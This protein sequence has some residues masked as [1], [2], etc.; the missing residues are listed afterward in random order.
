MGMG[1]TV[2]K[3]GRREA[4]ETAVGMEGKRSEEGLG[5]RRNYFQKL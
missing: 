3:R 4:N 2:G 1:E 5:K